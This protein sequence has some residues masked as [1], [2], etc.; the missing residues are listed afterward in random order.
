MEIKVTKEYYINDYGNQIQN[1]VKSVYLR[2]REIKYKEK[3][4]LKNNLYPGDYIIEI[5]KKIKKKK[6]LNFN[7]FQKF[8]EPLKKLSIRKL[9]VTNKK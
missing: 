7:N 4:I 9:N 6:K 8:Y 1:F 3:F 2:I 5:A